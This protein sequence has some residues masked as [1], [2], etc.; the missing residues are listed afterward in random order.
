MRSESC[1]SLAAGRNIY[2]DDSYFTSMPHYKGS[3][4]IEMT[5]YDNFYG[6]GF[7]DTWVNAA[8]N[9]DKASF[10]NSAADFS[11]LPG[12][13]DGSGN[14]VGREGNEEEEY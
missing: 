14:C 4:G 11:K 5:L 9:N 7:L 1:E 12:V 10:K 8:F 2:N 13:T 6:S 3:K